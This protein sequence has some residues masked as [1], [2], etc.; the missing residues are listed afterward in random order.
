ME[1]EGGGIVLS[2][3]WLC[4][5]QKCRIQAPPRYESNSHGKASINCGKVRP[6]LFPGV[7]FVR[8]SRLVSKPSFWCKPQN[9]PLSNE[10]QPPNDVITLCNGNNGLQQ[11]SKWQNQPLS[12]ERQPPNL[13]YTLLSIWTLTGSSPH[14]KSGLVSNWQLSI[15]LKT[16][17]NYNDVHWCHIW[18][19]H[20]FQW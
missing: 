19:D 10:R 13:V 9:Q 11:W 2:T 18:C 14:L 3:A 5:L 16:W 6:E 4:N 15:K 17:L 12:N 1:G 8:A 7:K 20:T